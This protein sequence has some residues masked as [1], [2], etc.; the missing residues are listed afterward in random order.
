MLPPAPRRSSPPMRRPLLPKLTL[1]VTVALVALLGLL[2]VGELFARIKDGRAGVEL[3]DYLPRSDEERGNSMYL[4]HPSLGY[5]MRPG[6]ERSSEKPRVQWTINAHGFR[7]DELVVPKPEGT[8][9]VLCVGGSTTFG[10]GVRVDE[11]SYPARL[12]TILRENLPPEIAIDVGNF[13][14]PGYTT[15]HTLI[16][17]ALRLTEYDADLVVV[18]HAA[19]DALMAQTEGF[20]PDYTHAMRVWSAQEVAPV[21]RF[22]IEN[23]RLFAQL[24]GARDRYAE[25]NLRDLVYVDGFD[26][27]HVPADRFM[28]REGVDVFLRN[29]RSIVDLVRGQR[30]QILLQTF[31]TDESLEADE[32]SRFQETVVAMNEGLAKIA[33]DRRVPIVDIARYL[34]DKEGNYVDWMHLNERGTETHA[35]LLAGPVGKIILKAHRE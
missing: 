5:V 21:E 2:V 24:S 27:L 8:F 11:D 31:A 17:L 32:G 12:Q 34:D 15:A 16:N 25:R 1:A 22:L 10:T 14:V 30:R 28:N 6:F 23:S 35:R 3:A 7:G 33:A 19:N 9:R 26:D 29:M 20:L 13:G 4:P 18:Y